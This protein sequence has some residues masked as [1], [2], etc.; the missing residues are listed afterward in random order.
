MKKI[1]S[2][3]LIIVLFVGCGY[4]EPEILVEKEKEVVYII[5]SASFTKKI[6]IPAPMPEQ[7][8]LGLNLK[9]KE[10]T[11]GLYSIQLLNLL[12]IENDKKV[13]LQ[14]YID[15]KQKDTK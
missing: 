10:K 4:K 13:E 15:D 3:L 9:D 7:E 12:H 11:L 8:Y 1:L 6:D 2:S 5:P 14:K